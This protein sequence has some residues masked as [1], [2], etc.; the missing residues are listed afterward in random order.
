MKTIL[1]ICLCA[2]TGYSS[3]TVTPEYTYCNLTITLDSTFDY[4]ILDSLYIFNNQD[5]STFTA[6]YDTIKKQTLYQCDSLISGTYTV[7]L[8]TI[9]HNEQHLNLTLSSDTS[10]HI[11]NALNVQVVKV[12]DKAVLLESDTIEFVYTSHGC[13]HRYIEKSILIK[14]PIQKNYSLHTYSNTIMDDVEPL[15]IYKKAPYSII[16]SL[17]QLQLACNGIIEKN[18]NNGIYISSTTITSLYILADNHLFQFSDSG[19]DWNLYDQF[20]TAYILKE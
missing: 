11:K 13:F 20:K 18:R 19:I 1:I 5:T 12:I 7:T 9:F 14:D 17:F 8:K 3:C 2:I 10:I 6:T 16:D 15:N 4:S